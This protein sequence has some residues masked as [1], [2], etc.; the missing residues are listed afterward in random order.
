MHLSV[1]VVDEVLVEVAL[2]GEL[3]SEQREVLVELGLRRDD[4]SVALFV[5]L[6]SSRPAKD[7]HHVQNIQIHKGS[8]LGVV[9]VRAL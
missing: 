9:D 4:C 1:E 3:A 2:N 8:M 5:K 7:L 6:G